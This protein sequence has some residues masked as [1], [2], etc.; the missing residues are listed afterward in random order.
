M[1]NLTISEIIESAFHFYSY[2]ESYAIPGYY[3][4]QLQDAAWV[5]AATLIFFTMQT[6][7]ALIEV[8]VIA[9]KNQ[10]NVMMRHIVDV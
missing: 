7:L 6:G 8:G 4:I 2:N 3:D 5:L 9:K 1:D 10:V